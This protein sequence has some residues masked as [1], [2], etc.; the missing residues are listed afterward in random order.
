M[1]NKI[2]LS[3]VCFM[4]LSVPFFAGTFT[5]PGQLA[6]TFVASFNKGDTNAF[7]SC[8]TEGFWNSTFDNPRKLVKQG[9]SIKRI[10]FLSLTNLTVVSNRAVAEIN[11]V[12]AE[13]GRIGDT[14]YLYAD[15]KTQGWLFKG[16]NEDKH[17][18]EKFMAGLVEGDFNPALLPSSKSLEELGAQILVKMPLLHTE[19]T[20]DE[21]IAVFQGVFTTH[22]Q[23]SGRIYPYLFQPMKKPLIT[24]TRW[25]ELLTRG[26]LTV[27]EAAT[28]ENPYPDKVVFYFLKT[29]AGWELYNTSSFLASS[30]FLEY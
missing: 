12:S 27:S 11:I 21:F 25:S 18:R 28:D 16:M 8:C 3:V 23:A 9:F 26:A 29:E 24:D 7:K 30:S 17:F 19:I 2:I 10:F 22:E 4:V 1:L 13:S 20:A 14:V 6:E 5:S 15:T